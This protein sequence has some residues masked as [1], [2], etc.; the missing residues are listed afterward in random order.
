MG[1]CVYVAWQLYLYR[2]F[3]LCLFDSDIN[4]YNRTRRLDDERRTGRSCY[5]L[6]ITR[7][8]N[9]T[10]QC[11]LWPPCVA[12]ADIIYLFCGFFFLL[13]IFCLSSIFF[14]A[15]YQPSQIG[16]LPYLHTWC[17]V[18]ANLDARMKRAAGGSL[19]IHGAKN[20]QKFAI[21]APSHNFV[22][23]LWD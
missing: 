4:R 15:Y 3:V 10:L 12:D 7:R 6:Y 14:L 21:W 13:F 22:R 9:C 16:C 11:S 18:S 19:K 2:L 17:G 1:N 20:C 23:L 8:C 5:E